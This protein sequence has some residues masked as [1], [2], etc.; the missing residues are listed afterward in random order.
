MLGDT[1]TQQSLVLSPVLAKVSLTIPSYPN[2]TLSSA[3]DEDIP[4][5]A[6]LPSMRIILVPTPD[7]PITLGLGRSLGAALRAEDATGH[8]ADISSTHTT[9]MRHTEGWRWSY[10]TSGLE[11]LQNY[12]AWTVENDNESQ[13]RGTIS[14][15]IL[16]S[17]KECE[18]L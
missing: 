3:F 18:R 17:T 5:P 6:N 7:S 8:I 1:I 4:A 11:P 2:Y 15:P 14:G 16:F 10:L 12:T 9:F 13:G